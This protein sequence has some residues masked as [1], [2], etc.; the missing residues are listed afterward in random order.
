MLSQHNVSGISKISGIIATL[1]VACIMWSQGAEGKRKPAKK[2]TLVGVWDIPSLDGS[3]KATMTISENKT[4]SL[5]ME[6][7]DGTKRTVKGKYRLAK[8]YT[9]F[10]K[11]TEGFGADCRGEASY[12]FA[13]KGDQV[14]YTLRNDRCLDRI[15]MFKTTWKKTSETAPEPT[16]ESPPDASRNHR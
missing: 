5:E 7:P 8:P 4:Y 6:Q 15:K 3:P 12:D 9:I 11:D 14:F 13:Q 1:M 16:K 2:E 10:L